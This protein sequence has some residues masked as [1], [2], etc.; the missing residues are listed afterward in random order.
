MNK[1][2]TIRNRTSAK[3]SAI[4]I[5][6]NVITSTNLPSPRNQKTSGNLSNLYVNDY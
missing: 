1:K 3:L 4:T 5:T 6:K 2:T